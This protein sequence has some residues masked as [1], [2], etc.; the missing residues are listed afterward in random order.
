M[1]SYDNFSAQQVP[2][3]PRPVKSRKSSS[4]PRRGV[5]YSCSMMILGCFLGFLGLFVIFALMLSAVS[6]SLSQDVEGV[7]PGLRQGGV[8]KEVIRE[9]DADNAIAVIPLYG[10]IMGGENYAEW[11]MVREINICLREARQD[12]K[13]KA[14]VLQVDSPGGGITASDLIHHEILQLQAAGK[15]V[16]ASVDSM[17]ASG[18]YWVIAP[19]KYIVVNP[20][21]IVGSFGVIMYRFKIKELF[22]KIGIEAMPEKSTPMKDLGS[23]FRDLSDKEREIFAKILASSH[24]RFVEVISTGRGLPVE[25]VEK[26]ADGS[27]FTGPE[28]VK[29]GLADEEGY[30]TTALAKAEELVLKKT[31]SAEATPP[32]IF[33]YKNINRFWQEMFGLNGSSKAELSTPQAVVNEL[34]DRASTPCIE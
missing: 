16:I 28:A 8:Y 26:L 10:A 29:L 1:S 19:A 25:E 30:F 3:S 34:L 31:P 18:A 6:S 13:V 2:P 27:I 5:L 15:P 17:A 24:Q 7:I 20:T 33:H 9:G 21:S 14:V 32:Q 4:P 22:D 12:D 23:P 11:N